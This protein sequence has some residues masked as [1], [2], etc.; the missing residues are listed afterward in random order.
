MAG[1]IDML[2]QALSDN[3]LQQMSGLLGAD[4]AK[5]KSGLGLAMPTLLGALAKNAAQPEGLDALTRAVKEDHDGS[6]LDDLG[7]FLSKASSGPGAGILKH[8]LGAKR[9]GVESEI[10]RASGLGGAAT[11]Q[12]LEMLAPIL[13]GVIGKSLASGNGQ[14]LASLL[15]GASRQ[16]AGAA[17]AGLGGLFGMLD[18]NKDGSMMDD[19]ARLGGGFFKRLLGMRR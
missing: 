14:G 10:S 4:T 2:G 8:V 11:G 16:A 17:P 19:V 5:T 13:M 9:T 18:L 6:I 12:L 3:T 1:L 15:S 7:G